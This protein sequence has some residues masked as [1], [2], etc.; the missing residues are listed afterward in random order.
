MTS[1]DDPTT[2]HRLLAAADTLLLDFDGP[3][4]SVFAGSPAPVVADQLRDILVEGG[5][6]VPAQVKASLD[7]FDVLHY[8]ATLGP[9]EARYA[10]AAFAA[11]E[12]E[13][14]TGAAPTPG[15][16]ELMSAWCGSNRPLFIVS[17]NSRTAI[18]AYIDLHGLRS[19]VA[20]VSAREDARVDRLKPNPYLVDQALAGRARD[21]A[22][23]VGDSA[24]DQQAAQAAHVPF[25]GFANKPEKI[26][27]LGA[28]MATS[29]R[30]LAEA[31]QR[32]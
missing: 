15:A 32:F 7:P 19:L 6:V 14:I 22:V 3:V 28:A 2:L 13:A 1:V 9:D 5:H 23:F 10:E 12:A 24:T 4:C 29:M 18:D 27:G 21:A 20:G 25:I 8:A 26:D 31:V 11:H 16:H 30:L 17:N